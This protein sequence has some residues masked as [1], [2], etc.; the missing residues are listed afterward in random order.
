VLVIRR[1]PGQSVRIGDEIEIE[2]VEVTAG[3]VKLGIRA[4]REISVLRSE[5]HLTGRENLAAAGGV[6][7]AAV[8]SLLR[9]LASGAGGEILPR[10]GN[11]PP[12]EIAHPPQTAPQP[13][14]KRNDG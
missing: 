11:L 14:D 8:E 2:V 12:L 5:I 13:A 4:P 6:T 1:K 9:G 7:P 3:K 10:A